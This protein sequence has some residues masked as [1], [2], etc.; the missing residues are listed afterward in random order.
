MLRILITGCSSG[1][2][3]AT[4]E[5]LSDRGHYVIGTARR[6]DALENLAVADRYLVDVTDEASI[7]STIRQCGPVDVLINNAGVNLVGPIELTP[8][9]EVARLFDTNLLGAL[10]MMQAVLPQMRARRGGQIVNISSLAGRR[11]RPLVGVYAATK[12]ALEF[13]TDALRFEVGHLGIKV[14]IVSPGPIE[15]NLDSHTTMIVTEEADY[16]SVY[17]RSFGPRWKIPRPVPVSDGA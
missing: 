8:I 7:S 17:D 6:M 4:S 13:V 11:V 1:L 2:G 9:A 15:T 3:R 14:S 16:R 5:M 10:R 12:S